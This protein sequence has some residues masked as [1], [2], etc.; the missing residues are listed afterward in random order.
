MAYFPIQRYIITRATH[1]RRALLGCMCPPNRMRLH[2]HATNMHY[3][4]YYASDNTS[5]TLARVHAL[6]PHAQ[7]QSASGPARPHIQISYVDYVVPFIIRLPQMNFERAAKAT[8]SL[9]CSRRADC[10]FAFG[11]I[12][13]GSMRGPL[14]ELARRTRAQYVHT[15][16]PRDRVVCALLTLVCM[17]TAGRG[18][19]A[20][21][22]EQ[23]TS[24]VS[25]GRQLYCHLSA[26]IC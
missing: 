13:T 5:E 23:C 22:A 25:A 17:R 19:V 24:R 1:N 2:G 6:S 15:T 4:F 20:A 16:P 10:A 21:D 12:I 11:D 7:T 3:V 8:A 26:I 9:A 14:R 18:A